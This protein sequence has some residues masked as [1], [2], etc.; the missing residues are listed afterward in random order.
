MQWRPVLSGCR[1]FLDAIDVS[2]KPPY[3]DRVTHIL[4]VEDDVLT[5]LALEIQ[6]QDLGVTVTAHHD[7]E[8]AM[9]QL[10]RPAFDAAIIDVALPG[11]RGDLFAKACR[12]AWPDMA[13]VLATGLS[14]REVRARFP[15]DLKVQILEKPYEFAVLLERFRRLGISI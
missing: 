2:L 4:V 8:S 11:M 10:T 13:I 14:E 12:H 9:A 5:G 7:A 3:G 6:L 1:Q 15:S